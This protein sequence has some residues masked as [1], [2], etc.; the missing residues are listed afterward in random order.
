MEP[1]HVPGTSISGTH[2]ES[3]GGSADKGWCVTTQIRDL[4][5]PQLAPNVGPDRCLAAGNT[6][7]VSDNIY[8]TN[9]PPP[10]LDR[11]TISGRHMT[12]WDEADTLL[13]ESR[14]NSQRNESRPRVSFAVQATP[15]IARVIDYNTPNVGV[16]PYPRHFDF[17][18]PRASSN[19]FVDG[20]T[21]LVQTGAA[22]NVPRAHVPTFAFD[23]RRSE[24]E[25]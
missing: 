1:R 3:G 8:G 21:P 14:P 20:Y 11:V 10:S 19:P 5:L 16:T 24:R 18:T 7:G 25:P 17:D 4:A 2:P 22:V 23:D 9:T 13:R 6:S 12:P 15:T